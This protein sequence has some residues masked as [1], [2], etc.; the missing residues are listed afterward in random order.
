MKAE[1]GSAIHNGAYKSKA[2]YSIMKETLKDWTCFTCTFDWYTGYT[3]F[4]INYVNTIDQL[5]I[6]DIFEFHISCLFLQE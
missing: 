1:L 3:R 4:S 2:S 6:F 5:I